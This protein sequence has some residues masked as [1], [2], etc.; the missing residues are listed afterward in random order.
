MFITSLAVRSRLLLVLAPILTLLLVAS[1][2]AAQGPAPDPTGS[3]FRLELNGSLT[4]MVKTFHDDGTWELTQPDGTVVG[5]GTYWYDPWKGDFFY[6]NHSDDGGGGHW[7]QFVYNEEHMRWDRVF[8]SHPKA[9]AAS[10]YL[11]DW[12]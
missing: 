11:A 2:A 9:P 6:W 3:S 5:H 12:F 7:G 1:P 8:S 10:L 4:D